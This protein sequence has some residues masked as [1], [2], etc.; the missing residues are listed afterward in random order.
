MKYS[1]QGFSIIEVVLATA[2]FMLFST[3]AITVILGGISSN[4]QGA[5]QTIANQF[6]AE[7]IEAVKS[8]K[9]QS[10]ASLVNST[11]AGVVKSKGVWTFSGANNTLFHN[12]TDNYIRV[13]KVEDVQ[14]DQPPPDGNI[15]PVGTVDPATKK[16]TSTVSWKASETRNNS[17]VLTTYLSNWR[18]PLPAN[19]GGILVYGDGG[20]TSD[21]IKYK[22]LAPV[23]G[24]WSAPSKASD[25]DTNTTNRAL[26]AARIYASSTRN[27]KILLSRHFD[28]DKQYIYGQVFNGTVWTI[29]QLFAKW[30]G[31]EFL[32]VR[33]FDGTYLNNGNF[34]AVYSDNTN[35]P[36][37]RIWNWSFWTNPQ[38]SLVNLSNN[39]KGVPTYIVAKARPGT[40]EV[41]AAFF[42]K[43]KDTHTQYYNGSTWTLH[44]EKANNAP[45]NTKEMIDF[46]WS[47]QNN[48]KGALI[49]SKDDNRT[50]SLRIWTANQSGSGS[51]SEVVNAPASSGKVGAMQ[52]DGR[53]GREEFIACQKDEENNIDCFRA[54]TLPS[55]TTPT[56][57][58]LTTKSDKGI[59][60]SFDFSFEA[61]SGTEGL[62]VYA[63][64]SSTPQYRKYDAT[65]NSFGTETSLTSALKGKLKTVGL[66][67][68]QDNDDIMMIM[69][70]ANNDMYSVVWNGSSN[71][72]YTSPSGKALS[73]HGTNG[74]DTT[75]FWYDFAWDRH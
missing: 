2:I 26:R 72:V 20:T 43:Q 3:A 67:P 37:Y 23:T 18:S 15:V 61:T 46:S 17:V 63:N 52:I 35:S 13:I 44:Q 39:E 27:E 22:I 11:G 31:E 50:L 1:S 59:Q 56:N 74:S 34:M 54:D 58:I 14:R 9:N 49:F 60:R 42:G 38:L 33:N 4:R 71:A 25:V 41:M 64:N 45:E 69:A 12:S 10:F 75:E 40:N 57:N 30:N 68:L 55:F 16:I 5:E 19:T 70:D 28:G 51:W 32:D 47:P 21:A 36:K 8:I 62:S 6:A 7:A 73:T 48:L 66:I 65:G 29:P 53:K 24:T